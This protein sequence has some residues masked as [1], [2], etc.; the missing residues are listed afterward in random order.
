MVGGAGK[1]GILVRKGQ[2]LTSEAV[3]ERL[4]TGAV[5]QELS[6]RTDRLHFRKISGEGPAEG[7]ISTKL[8]DKALVV[9]KNS[10]PVLVCFYS[11]GMT[12]AQGFSHLKDLLDSAKDSGLETLVLDH[13]TEEPYK[14]CKDWPSYLE[15]LQQQVERPELRSRP[16]ILF[17]HSHGSL[18]AY[19]LAKRLGKRVLKFFV[20]A[21]RPPSMP[22]LDEV[23]GVSKGADI[24]SLDEAALLEGLVGAWRNRMLESMRGSS[25]PPVAK[26]ILATVREQYASPCAPGGSSELDI[27]KGADAAIA[28]PILAFACSQEKEKGETASKMEGWRSLTSSS[29]EM[30]VVEADHMDCLASDDKK[31]SELVQLLMEDIKKLLQDM[32]RGKSPEKVLRKGG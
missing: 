21:R 10:T 18:A 17:A 4:G 20:A 5:I 2:E 16:L 15:A 14:T 11:G 23:W 13:A 6:L 12:A 28:A 1:G 27:F 24:Q 29:F 31:T 30:K 22:L 8:K 26:K 7:W 9:R 3:E 25:L 32:S 19:G